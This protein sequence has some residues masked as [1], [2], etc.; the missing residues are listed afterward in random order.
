MQFGRV[1]GFLT[2]T[3]S[4]ELR[5]IVLLNTRQR[6]IIVRDGAIPAALHGNGLAWLADQLVQETVGN[7]LA[8]VGWEVVGEASQEDEDLGAAA[9]IAR[10]PC[11]VVRRV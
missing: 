2:R 6:V 1:E 11:Y 7:E 8:E 9:A 4:G 5:I 10:S 3:Q